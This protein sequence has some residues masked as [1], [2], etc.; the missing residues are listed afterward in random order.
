MICRCRFIQ[1]IKSEW[2]DVE[3][4][5]AEAAAQYFH[6]DR[7]H[8]CRDLRFRSSSGGPEYR[9]A[10]VEVSGAGELV[11]RVISHGIYRRGGV[12]LLSDRE[13][14]QRIA[15]R[16]GWSH[17]PEELIVEWAGE[18]PIGGPVANSPP[19]RT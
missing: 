1:P 15:D 8:M 16:L 5:S 3:A 19:A 13:R 7:D 17:P 9:F 10:L 6:F 4:S 12:R 14:L 11:S 18:E 2:A